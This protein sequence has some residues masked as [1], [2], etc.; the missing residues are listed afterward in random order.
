M[1]KLSKLIATLFGLGYSPF[2][3]GTIA[4]IAG[5]FLYFILVKNQ[6]IYVATSLGLVILGFWACNKAVSEFDKK[7]PSCIVI[8]EFAAMLL[9]YLFVP[10]SIKFTVI[11]FVLFRVFD[12]FKMPAIKRLERFPKG[13]GIMLDDIAAAILTNI[14]LHTIRLLPI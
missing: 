10:F 13:Y 14:L 4:S 6:A 7:D 9:V 2:A 12:I 8:D 11:G 5:V 1:R 3:P